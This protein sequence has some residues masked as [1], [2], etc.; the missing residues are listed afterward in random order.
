MLWIFYFYRWW[1]NSLNFVPTPELQGDI[2]YFKHFFFRLMH[3][4]WRKSYVRFLNWISSF[5][6]SFFKIRCSISLHINSY[7]CDDTA[8]SCRNFTRTSPPDC[9]F[10]ASIYI[11][12]NLNSLLTVRIVLWPLQKHNSLLQIKCHLWSS[13]IYGVNIGPPLFR[14]RLKSQT[15]ELTTTYSVIS[16]AGKQSA[17][18]LRRQS[19][20]VAVITR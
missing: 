2:T 16:I 11:F 6:F 4:W 12:L 17:K 3:V 18:K 5:F 20:E 10:C 14:L 1:R 8:S 13:F 9:H 19:D 7:I 15:L